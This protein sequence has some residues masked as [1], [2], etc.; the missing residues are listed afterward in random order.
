MN[1][2]IIVPTTSHNFMPVRPHILVIFQDK[3]A[4][5]CTKKGDFFGRY[6]A[7][8]LVMPEMERITNQLTWPMDSEQY[9]RQLPNYDFVERFLVLFETSVACLLTLVVEV[10]VDDEIVRVS[11]QTKKRH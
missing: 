4:E 1:K 10:L 3:H 9:V 2:Y 7:L 8:P 11:L 6:I 5:I